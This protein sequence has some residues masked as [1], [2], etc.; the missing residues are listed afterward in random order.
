MRLAPRVAR[1]GGANC[2]LRP[3]LDDVHDAL[4]V[5]ERPA[6]DD[7]A[8]VPPATGGAAARRASSSVNRIASA[9]SSA[10]VHSSSGLA[11]AETVRVGPDV[12]K[13]GARHRLLD[14]VPHP[15][16]RLDVR[17]DPLLEAHRSER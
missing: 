17:A 11:I 12:P 16:V 4:L 3:G 2:A 9:L 6:E 5:G 10:G 15:D 8:F 13:N 14:G 1:E 7:H